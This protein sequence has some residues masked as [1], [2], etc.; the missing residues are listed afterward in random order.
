MKI[1][2]S[3]A[4]R[5]FRDLFNAKSYLIAV[6]WVLYGCYLLTGM[7][8]A[9]L[10]R[11]EFVLY[12]VSDHY[13]LTYFLIL[14]L[15]WNIL[16]SLQRED[17]LVQIRVKDHRKYLLGKCMGIFLYTLGTTA[18]CMGISWILGMGFPM[19][20]LFLVKNGPEQFICYV[21]IFRTPCQAIMA[22]V[23][24]LSLGMAVFGGVLFCVNQCLKNQGM[25]VVWLICY[26]SSILGL[27]MPDAKILQFSLDKFLIYHHGSS[28]PGGIHGILAIL[29]L[30]SAG[31]L[32]LSGAGSKK[33][34]F[35]VW[36]EKRRRQVLLNKWYKKQIAVCSNC[37]AAFLSVCLCVF[38]LHTLQ[39]PASLGD[40]IVEVFMGAKPLELSL[41][42]FMRMVILN[43][44]PV[45]VLA[46]YLQKNLADGDSIV[47]IRTGRK[48]AG[49]Y[50]MCHSALSFCAKYILGIILLLL[51]LGLVSGKALWGL[52]Y[53]EGILD[54]PHNPVILCMLAGGFRFLEFTVVTMLLLLFSVLNRTAAGITLYL[55]TMICYFVDGKQVWFLRLFGI[56]SLAG[57]SCW[58]GKMEQAML[59]ISC[60][61]LILAGI[62]GFT[63]YQLWKRMK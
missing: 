52:S 39:E 23:C 62:L 17:S 45:F 63:S 40:M 33:R 56:S 41:A 29:L 26:A 49:F 34:R 44:V 38:S 5:T 57:F 9:S 3:I 16:Q 46:A 10:T 27:H 53:Y 32:I 6:I 51:F 35:L 8:G 24:F 58:E 54:L 61:S 21:G 59:Q 47:K 31:I 4:R 30:L 2:V 15:S 55:C 12:M 25:M 60:Y 11:W 48:K 14:I 22:A 13:L 7:Q 28:A 42:D 1:I 36:R 18:M 50:A 37:A 19:Q 20:N 43:I